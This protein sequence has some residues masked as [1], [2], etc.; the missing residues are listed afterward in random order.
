MMLSGMLCRFLWRW[1]LS[2]GTKARLES[3]RRSTIL[4]IQ[5]IALLDFIP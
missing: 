3:L 1:S 2:S 4:R 5:G